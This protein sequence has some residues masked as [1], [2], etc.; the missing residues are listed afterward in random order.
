MEIGKIADIGI[1]NFSRC[2]FYLYNIR[3]QNYWKF[4]ALIN[5]LYFKRVNLTTEFNC[6]ILL[7]NLKQE[8]EIRTIALV[9]SQ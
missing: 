5:P 6:K 3:C 4:Q 1:S 7:E 8:N 2:F 9:A